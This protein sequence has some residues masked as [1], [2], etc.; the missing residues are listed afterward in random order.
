MLKKKVWAYQS[1]QAAMRRLSLSLAN[2]FAILWRSLPYGSLILRA[3]S[4]GAGLAAH[5][6][7]VARAA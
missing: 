6:G 2:M 4:E 1:K 5:L 3:L 7:Q